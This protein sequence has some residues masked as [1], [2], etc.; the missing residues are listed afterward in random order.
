[1]ANPYVGPRPFE[2][3]DRNRFFG[4]DGEASEVVSLVIAHRVLLLYAQSGAGK[5]SLINAGIIPRLKEEEDFQVLPSA[6][7]RGLVPEDIPH[8]GISNLYAFNTLLSWAGPEF[9]PRRLAEQS[10]A[11]FLA[12]AEPYSFGLPVNQSGG[13]IDAGTGVYTAGGG[14]CGGTDTV[15]ATDEAGNT[16]DAT[17]TVVDSG[18][19][20][21]SPWTG[22]GTGTTTAVS[23]GSRAPA[24]FRYDAPVP[25]S[26][27]WEFKAT[28]ASTGTHSLDWV[29]SGFHSFFRVTAHLDAFVDDGTTVMTTNLVDAGPQNC[30]ISPSNGFLFSGTETFIVQPGDVYGFRI[31]GSH[32]DSASQLSGR[33]TVIPPLAID[34]GGEGLAAVANHI[35]SASGGAPP[36]SFGRSANNSGAPID[37]STGVHTAGTT[38]GVSDAGAIA[39]L[40]MV[41]VDDPVSCQDISGRGLSVGDGDPGTGVFSLPTEKFFAPSRGG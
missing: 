20:A 27:T 39:A 21:D 31:S 36:Y 13:S 12:E 15:R 26:G 25:F 17:V 41:A 10:L 8:Q 28:A 24:E 33:L 29:Y 6:R 19:M 9:D 38:S 40:A 37:A 5:S 35:F 23:D 4:R 22:S 11:G 34:P 7:V 18:S 3:E 16:S 1:M 2:P 14:P 30:C 32:F